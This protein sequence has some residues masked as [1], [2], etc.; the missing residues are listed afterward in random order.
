MNRKNIL[1]I[2]KEPVF[3]VFLLSFG[4]RLFACLNTYIINPDGIHYI[5]QARALF[6][7][8]WHSLTNCHIKYISPLP[9]LIAAAF[10]VFRD[11]VI[12]GRF[13]S[14]LFSFATLFPLYFLLRRFFD[15][16][17]T[18][19]TLL[20][21][22]LIPFLVSRSAD[23]VR[24][25]VF[26]FLVCS[27]MFLFIH[28]MDARTFN[29][30]RTDLV[31]SCCLFILS[32]WTRIE[33][34]VFIPASCVYLLIRKSDQRMQ[35][36]F[37]FSLPL[38]LAF[39]LLLASTQ[40]S[41]RSHESIYRTDK[42]RNELT[43]F[44]SQYKEVRDQLKALSKEYPL[45]FGEFLR[46]VR[47]VVWIVP[48]AIILNTILEGFFYPYALLFFLGFIGIRGRPTRDGH[49]GYFVLLFSFGVG[50]LYLHLLQ[51]W[52]I[53]NRFLSILIFPSFLLFGFGIE[54]ALSFLRTKCRLRPFMAPVWVV[55]FI[56]AFG[57]GKN[58]RA[59]HEDKI[60]Y[61]QA[62]EII[63]S[64]KEPGQIAKIAGVHSTVYEWVFF[65]AHRNYPGPLC[66][67]NLLKKI[68]K[69]YEKLIENMQ[70][71]GT[72]YLFFEENQW[73]QKDMDL[74]SAPYQQDFTILGQWHHKDT[75][76]LML[77]QLKNH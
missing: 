44:T 69:S 30:C 2:V 13:I 36:F 23:I 61:R 42:V 21:Y 68:P 34:A 3:W 48:S 59:N 6:Y 32:A 39:L 43:Q 1:K 55:A 38:L 70:T 20:V 29:R 27:G 76:N 74:T 54:N 8:E 51:T 72:R 17:I 31:F 15:K 19:A 22:A 26:W 73:P 9:F 52:L 66:A 45:A 47:N 25:P 46:G 40:F 60:V 53:Y 75:G 37:F 33:G 49:L 7:N 24:D 65:Y 62:G 4:V 57:L 50:V 5:H 63:A 56:L 77:L 18:A 64:Q 28:S 10:G 58:I 41:E 11:W 67:K 35:R 14:L 71:S 16:T 12:A